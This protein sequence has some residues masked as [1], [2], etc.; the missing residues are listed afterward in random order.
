MDSRA[1]ASLNDWFRVIALSGALIIL[2]NPRNGAG[3]GGVEV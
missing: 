2:E 1:P 3:V